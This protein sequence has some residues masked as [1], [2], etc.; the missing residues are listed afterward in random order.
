MKPLRGLTL[1]AALWP[2]LALP[3]AVADPMRPLVSPG[4]AAAASASPAGAANTGSTLGSDAAAPAVRRLL[5]IRQDSGGERSALFG[6]RWL[7][8][9]DLYSAPQGATLVLAVGSNHIELEQDKVKTIHHLLAP[10]LPPQWPTLPVDRPLTKPATSAATPGAKGAA[11]VAPAASATPA[12][13]VA[14]AAS[15]ASVAPAATAATAAPAAPEPRTER[16]LSP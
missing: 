13:A 14:P 10:L 3:P 1:C 11:P 4:A 15:A 7:R 8:A 5:A 9:G 6:D 12:A 16:P 2:G